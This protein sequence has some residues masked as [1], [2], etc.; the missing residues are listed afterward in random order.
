MNEEKDE[1]KLKKVVDD[2]KLEDIE[3]P[4]EL[5][6]ALNQLSKDQNIHIN[7]KKFQRAAGFK[8]WL[9]L[10]IESI[11]TIACGIG[12]IGILKPF[13]FE[14]PYAPYIYLA[15]VSFLIAIVKIALRFMKIP[16]LF[17]F[18]GI[19]QY[20]FS[21]LFIVIFSIFVPKV[22]INNTFTFGLFVLIL[23]FVDSVIRN[24]IRRF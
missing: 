2:L 8:W 5:I 13:I 20:I 14:N 12:L 4:E 9:F 16:F 15:G 21:I 1:E 6:E 3:S 19:L 24:L 17:L 23:E 18:N 7:V 11:L 10:F 22:Y